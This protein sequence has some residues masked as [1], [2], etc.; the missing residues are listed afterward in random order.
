MDIVQSERV[1]CSNRKGKKLARKIQDQEARELGFR[2]FC[3]GL[4]NSGKV[5]PPRGRTFLKQC[6]SA[7]LMLSWVAQTQLNWSIGRPWDSED[8][9]H[10]EEELNV[11]DPY[12]ICFDAVSALKENRPIQ[13]LKSLAQIALRFAQL[14][15]RQLF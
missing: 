13:E 8:A 4:G 5:K 15:R 11:E 6:F 9:Y 3:V 1:R 12:V 7:F 14:R 10:F 2:A